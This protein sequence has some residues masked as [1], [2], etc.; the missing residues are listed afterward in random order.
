MPTATTPFRALS[1]HLICFSAVSLAFLSAASARAQTATNGVTWNNTGSEW[2]NGTSWFGGVA[3]TNSATA[4]TNNIATFSNA[5]VGNNIVNLGSP[6]G[7]YG[8]VFTAGAN[9]YT[10]TGSALTIRSTPT[11]ISNGSASTQTFST[12]I[13]NT[14]VKE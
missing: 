11:S 2:T 7:I 6:Q 13:I 4:S 14:S 1:K 3:P 9:A 8:V 5:A 10:F 12:K